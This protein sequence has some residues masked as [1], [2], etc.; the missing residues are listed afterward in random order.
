[1]CRPRPD[2]PSRGWR[3]DR[4]DLLTDGDVL[5]IISRQKELNFRPGTDYITATPISSCWDK[6]SAASAVTRLANSL[7]AASSSRSDAAYPCSRK[8]R[9]SHQGH[10]LPLGEAAQRLCS[11]HP[12]LRHGRS[13]QRR[14]DRRGSCTMGCEPLFR[15]RRRTRAGPPVNE[16]GKLTDGTALIYGNG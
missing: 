10:S 3:L 14:D 16:P 6:R 2:V 13:H 11:Q 12:K 15:R 5:S 9:R 7:P 8:P 1:M 4:P